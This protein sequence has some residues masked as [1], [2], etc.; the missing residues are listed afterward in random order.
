MSTTEKPPA[1][2]PIDIDEGTTVILEGPD[3]QVRTST[4]AIETLAAAAGKAHEQLPLFER[5]R[6]QAAEI[7]F[8]GSLAEIDLFDDLDRELI[9]ALPWGA[10]ARLC[11]TVETPRGDRDI[12]LDA[13]VGGRSFSFKGKDRTPTTTVKVVVNGRRFDEE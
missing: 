7:G 4:E 11:L 9:D 13:E 5:K 6:V 3:G 10:R 2:E 1:A 8:S 12:Y